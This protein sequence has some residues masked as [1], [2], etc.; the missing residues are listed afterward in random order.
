MYCKWGSATV[1][2]TIALCWTQSSTAEID[3]TPAA[4]LSC[5]APFPP[6]PAMIEDSSFEGTA[7]SSMV[8]VRPCRFAVHYG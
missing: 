2:K 1:N 6:L 4:A 5:T 3:P 7:S 8:S